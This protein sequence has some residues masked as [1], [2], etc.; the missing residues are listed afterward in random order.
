M[1]R[2]RRWCGDPIRQWSSTM[3]LSTTCPKEWWN[4]LVGIKIFHYSTSQQPISCMSKLYFACF[5]IKHCKHRTRPKNVTCVV[6]ERFQ[7]KVWR[8]GSL[9]KHQKYV[10]EWEARERVEPSNGGHRVASDY[11]EYLVWPHRST[12]IS[13]HPPVSSI[14]IDEQGSDDDNM[15]RTS[16]QPQSAPLENYMVS[17][18]IHLCL[19]AAWIQKYVVM[20]IMHAL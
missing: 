4:S 12:R 14:P 2:L 7:E 13:V 18:S 20:M 1:F 10:Q 6:L 19:H 17:I 15:T 8:L 5:I 16:M 3:W 9:L 11:L